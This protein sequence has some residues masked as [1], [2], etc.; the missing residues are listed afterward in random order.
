MVKVTSERIPDSQI[1]LEIEV[2][3]ERIAQSLE[4]A[5]RR[6]VGRI[7]VPGFRRGKAP[8]HIVERVVGKEALVSEG[9]EDLVGDVYAQALKDL[10]LH[11]VAQP[12]VDLDPKPHDLKP[13]DSLTVKATVSVEPI[14][15]L[16]DY[17]A[18]RVQPLA[19]AI[20]DAEVNEVVE[21]I[22]EQQAEWVPV[23][24]PVAE[25]D[26]IVLDIHGDV[27]TYTQLYSASGQPLVQSG[28]GTPIV[29]EQSVE[30][31]VEAASTRYPTGVVEQIVGMKPGEEKQFELSLPPDYAEAELAN[32]LAIFKAKI[33]D[34]KEKH[35]PG[36]D[37]E[38]AK[39]VGF[40]S[41]DLLRQ[42]VRETSQERADR[43][44]QEYFET[45]VIGEAV[46]RATFEVPSVLVEH[47]MDHR[48][49][50]A[51]DDLERQGIEFPTF[52]RLT[53]RT[54]D[55]FRGDFRDQA[56]NSVRSSI[57]INRIAEVEGIEAT[58]AE[59]DQE[60]EQLV[61]LSGAQGQRVRQSLAAPDQREALG[62]RI[63]RRK[64]VL[65]L[66]AI[67]RTQIETDVAGFAPPTGESV[68]TSEEA[69]EGGASEIEASSA[70]VETST[71]ESS[72]ETVAEA[73][74]ETVGEE[75][76]SAEAR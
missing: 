12:E 18:I 39:T 51:K 40:D 8:R 6:V 21:R 7:N 47:E 46:N 23:E 57:V 76:S 75:S 67:A 29:D 53:K 42:G 63:A 45:A 11:P 73:P 26:R 27:G 72:A 54:E 31:T 44:A 14:V 48:L 36:Y 33:G 38:F 10:D 49:E 30:F 58:P 70:E 60:I 3:P 35:L 1:R 41:F 16:G 15:E 37:D 52:L 34:V 64:T 69:S 9:L 55:E 32:R 19:V 61:S 59:I 4:K 17:H 43:Q 25:G 62:R 56:L 74:A 2:E 66:E 28:G 71:E 68:G 24:R 22:R 5:Y 50:H 65:Y 13:G 20:T